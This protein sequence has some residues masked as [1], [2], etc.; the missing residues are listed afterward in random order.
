M[1]GLVGEMRRA[2]LHLCDFGIGIGLAC[3][4]LVREL[5]ALAV[6]V[7]SDE[8]VDRRRLDAA[9]PGHPR[10][11]LAIG[12]ASVAAQHDRPHRG[13][14]L[15]RR[16][17]DADPFALHQTTLGDEVQNPAEHLLMNFVRKTAARLR[18]PGMVGDL[19]RFVSRRNSRSDSESEQRQTMARSPSSP[20]KITDYMLAE[21]AAGGSE[22]GRIEWFA[23]FLDENLEAGLAQELLQAVI[24]HMTRR[25]RHLTPCHH[26][27]T[28]KL[29]LTPHCHRCHS[30]LRSSE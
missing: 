5:F 7:E 12:F 20:S 26:E 29:R 21:I 15:H 14:G 1:F 27:V 8:V 2:V 4:V 17:V 30:L 25:A 23:G 19:S 18:Q 22:G 11:H 6:A 10:Q 16:T 28:L 3:P 24:E 13:I 9:L